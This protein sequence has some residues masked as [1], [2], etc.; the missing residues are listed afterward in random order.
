ML[1]RCM[2]LLILIGWWLWIENWQLLAILFG[3][4]LIVRTI[5]AKGGWVILFILILLVVLIH[6]LILW[7][8]LILVILIWVMVLPINILNRSFKICGACGVNYLLIWLKTFSHVC[9]IL[10]K[11]VQQICPGLQDWLKVRIGVL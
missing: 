3:C 6:G 8:I 5:K 7:N 1:H 4:T 10:L 9:L 11:R 2:I